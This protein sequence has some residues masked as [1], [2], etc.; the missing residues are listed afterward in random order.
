MNLHTNSGAI[1]DQFYEAAADGCVCDDEQAMRA[2]IASAPIVIRRD[3]E[4][5]GV[6]VISPTLI[7]NVSLMTDLQCCCGEDE[8]DLLQHYLDTSIA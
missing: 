2:L 7:L 4:I 3:D 5:V 8:Y 6:W 1:W